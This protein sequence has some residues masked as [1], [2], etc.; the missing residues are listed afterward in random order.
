MFFCSVRIVGLLWVTFVPTPGLVRGSTIY[1]G[2]D[3]RRGINASYLKVGKKP[4]GM[5][6]PVRLVSTGNKPRGCAPQL[7]SG[8]LPDLCVIIHMH[9]IA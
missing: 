7:L 6:S 5:V 9:Y 8:S 3:C 2:S 1:P 4:W